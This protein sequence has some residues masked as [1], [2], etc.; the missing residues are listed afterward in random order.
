M[1][2]APPKLKLPVDPTRDHI[3]GPEDAPVTLVEYGDYQCPYCHQVE[4]V[5]RQLGEEIGHKYRY[6]FRHFPLAGVHERA[7]LAAEAA[8]AA[9]AQGKFWEMHEYLSMRADP[10]E[11]DRERLIAY[12]QE[13]GLDVERFTR[14]LDEH[15]YADRV[16]EDYQSGVRSGV[17]RTPT[18]FIDDVRYD[19][20]W[21]LKSLR[22]A[23]ER[24]LGTRIRMLFDEFTRIEALGGIL[25]VIVTLIALAWANLPWSGAYFGLWHTELA[26]ELG[27]FR[28][29]YD[30]QHWVNDGL[31]AIFFFVVGLEIKREVLAGE[32]SRPRQAILSIAAAIG[33]MLVPAA[34]YLALN[35]GTEG[36]RGWGVPVATDIA[37]TLGLLTLLG[38]RVPA[39]LK[40]FFTAMAIAD[41][42]GAVMVIALFYTSGVSWLALGIGAAFLAALVG[43][44][45]ARV[46]QPL[47]Y[48]LLGIGLWLAFLK[49][50]VHPTVAGVLL[51]MTIPARTQADTT[52]FLAQ[53]TAILSDFERPGAT[54]LGSQGGRRQA[55]VQTLETIAER[56]ESP[57]QRLERT[58]HPW[59]TY[60]VVPIFA[61]ANAGVSLGGDLPGALTRPVSLGI[62]AGLVVGKPLGISLAS[63][64]AVRLGLADLPQGVGW[65]ALFSA[66]FLA[67]IGFTMS[68][69]IAGA[70][71]ED[72]L[73]LDAAKIG[74]IAASLIAA[75]TGALLLNLTTTG[76][77]G[78]TR[79]DVELAME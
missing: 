15:V 75:T 47:P 71:F 74:I 3:R 50:G 56:L 1:A 35:A 73:L 78:V 66:S 13:I 27:R 67:G 12:A 40:V 70:G 44:N 18:F 69:F 37:F 10:H 32:L 53:C 2:K 79:A 8:E 55:A 65:P 49:S 29:A 34:L 43:L 72:P 14:E 25:L 16:R 77:R 63:W 64:L 57:L 38:S 36:A 20:A 68:L 59:T 31:M 22:D 62:I 48:A 45:R 21:D 9:A 19:G 11:L 28:L 23:I 7:Q 52:A 76:Y 26:I 54:Q 24:P 51:A 46:Y 33:G 4:P 41:D 42:L 17:D 58:L 39:S 6:V 61:L 60:V 30:L 5:L